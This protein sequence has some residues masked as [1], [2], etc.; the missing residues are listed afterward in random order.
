MLPISLHIETIIGYENT[1]NPRVSVL[2]EIGKIV[3]KT[4]SRALVYAKVLI[5]KVPWFSLVFSQIL[6][7]TLTHLVFSQILTLTL[8]FKYRP[9]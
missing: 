7:L 2:S 5:Q 3:V 8:I 4:D 1:P 9:T 6:T